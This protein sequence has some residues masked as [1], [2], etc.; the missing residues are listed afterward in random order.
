MRE[1]SFAN[2]RILIADDQPA[3]VRMLE[4]ML[5]RAGYRR[6]SSTC[7]PDRIV[8]LF[9]EFGPDLLLLDLHMPEWEGINVLGALREEV[10]E[11]SKV[12][13]LMLTAETDQ[14]ARN[15]AL[16][17]GAKDFLTKP[18]DV[19]EVLLRIHNLLELRFLHR[20]LQS[21][22]AADAAQAD[23]GSTPSGT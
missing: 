12:P 15:A 5:K 13:V 7:D 3:N 18:F 14:G 2:A 16:R 17:F 10:P 23:A 11:S 6:L 21:R 8:P 19:N 20:Q 1:N 4:R 9:Q 22:S